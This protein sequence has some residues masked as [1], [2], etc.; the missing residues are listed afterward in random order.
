[1]CLLERAM[2]ALVVCLVL[3]AANV[4]LYLTDGSYHV[5]REFEVKADRVRFYS[6]ERSDWEEIPLDLVDL[7]RTQKLVAERQAE[8]QATRQAERAE[9]TAVREMEKEVASVPSQVGPYWIQ[10]GKLTALKQAES[11]VTSNK[12]R[13]ILKAMSPIP[14]V[15]GKAT[16]ELDGPKSAFVVHEPR[17]EFYFRLDKEEQFLI[18]RCLASK[19]NDRIVEK[20]TIVPVTKELV[21]EHE[22]VPSFRHQVGERLYKIWPQ[23][24]LE[25]GEHAIVELTS[26]KSNSR[27]WDF[28]YQPEAGK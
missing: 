15:T 7:K 12:R 13:S 16:L 25:P 9:R 17:P 20:W 6:V 2:L 4:R 5:V 27:I 23:K 18:V 1:M 21:Q 14:V 26:G 19:S 28:S 8:I 3:G 11:K 22:E 24:P 10:P